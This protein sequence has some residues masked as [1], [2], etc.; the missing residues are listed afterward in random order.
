[1]INPDNKDITLI[2][3]VKGHGLFST[4]WKGWLFI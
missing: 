2:D 3:E 1:M 4:I